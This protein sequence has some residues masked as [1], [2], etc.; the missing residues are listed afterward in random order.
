M[1]YADPDRWQHTR[2]YAHDSFVAERRTRIVIGITATMMVVEIIGG[3][4]IIGKRYKS[5]VQIHGVD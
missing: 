2:N 5:C 3:I 4:L 1:Q